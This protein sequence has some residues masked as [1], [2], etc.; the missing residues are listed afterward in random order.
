MWNAFIGKVRRHSFAIRIF[1]YL[2]ARAY[3]VIHRQNLEIKRLEEL[4]KKERSRW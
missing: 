3:Y 1:A 4:L 2:I